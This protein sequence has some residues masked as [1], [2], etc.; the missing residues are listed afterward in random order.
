[1][2]SKKK[3]TEFLLSEMSSIDPEKYSC[4]NN[5][6]EVTT[7]QQVY[8][9]R[10]EGK[11]E[12]RKK[13][14]TMFSDKEFTNIILC[15]EDTE[16]QD[17]IARKETQISSVLLPGIV[18]KF[19][20]KP[21][22]NLYFHSRSSIILMAELARN[23]CL[24]IAE[25]ATGEQ[26]DLPGTK[27]AGKIQHT[28]M[29]MHA[30]EA[31]LSKEDGE[32]WSRDLYRPYRFAERVSDTNTATDFA[33]WATQIRNDTKLVSQEIYGQQI[34]PIPVIMRFDCALEL[35]NGGVRGYRSE[36]QVDTGKMYNNVVLRQMG[37]AQQ[38]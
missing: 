7:V 33:E 25:D 10:S 28:K 32:K 21:T 23:N 24:V 26:Y 6:G 12:E 31:L 4:G 15:M 9:M 17:L 37:E 5:E 3:P 20:V 8:H 34:D 35:L 22:F 16:K 13:N 36:G 11:V 14:G 38:I 19:H 30:S 27:Y 18:R 29:V 1:M 2:T